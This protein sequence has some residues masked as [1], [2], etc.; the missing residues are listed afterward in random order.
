MPLYEITLE[1][2]YFGNQVINRWNYLSD[3]APT[4]VLGAFKG[5]VG[6][7]FAPDTG[8][9]PFDAA[10]IAGILQSLQ[11]TEAEFVQVI[12]KNLYSVTDFYTYAFPPG[13][14]GLVTGSQ[15]MSPIDSFGYASNRTRSDIRRAQKRFTGL[16]EAN[17]EAGGVLNSGYAAVAQTLGDA[18]ATPLSVAAGV[19]TMTFTPQVFG[20]E[21]YTTPR[22][23]PAYRYYATE[24]EQL[25]HIALISAFNLKP[26]VRSQTSRQ[27]GRGS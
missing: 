24:A 16:N 4:G 14:H 5:I 15:A 12:A 19:G 8:I 13:T 7:G 3:A 6:M 25:D 21:E 27:Y 9:T 11:A 23:N 26:Q 10:T 22:G 1:Q 20:R 18:M 2:S 17:V